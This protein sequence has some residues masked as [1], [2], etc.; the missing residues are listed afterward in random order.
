MLPVKYVFITGCSTGIGYEVAHDLHSRDD[1]HVIASCRQ[2]V[3]VER[4]QQE[5]LTCLHLDLTSQESIDNAVSQLSKITDG[6]LYGLFNNGAYGQ[7]GAL[8]DLPTQALR[9]QFETNFFSWHEL[10]R[11]ILPLMRTQ[12]EGRIIQNSSVLGFAAMKYRGAYN[13]SKFALE[14]WTD[15]LR[16]ELRETN[17][18]ISLLE[19]GPIE[20]QFR[21]NA[22]IAFKKWITVEGSHHE[23]R[24]L[25]QINRLSQKKSE[26]H[27][28]LPASSCVAPVIHALTAN[29]PKIRYKV[30]VPTL[31]FGVLKRLLPTRLLDR[32]L[33]S[34]A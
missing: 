31:V 13:A 16:L 15:T 29:R 34:A 7:T 17:I 3:D 25:R 12:G 11:Q 33:H 26:K 10:T 28:T 4:L 18:H 20:T 21:A 1:F 9:E 5:G 32:I 19:P 6:Q 8:E 27:F 30:T 14:G 2:L 22:L 24:Y 23:E